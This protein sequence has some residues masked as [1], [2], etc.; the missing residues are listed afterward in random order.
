MR[1]LRILPALA[2][3]AM[4]L[5]PPL[6][7][8]A[9]PPR[10]SSLVC[11]DMEDDPPVAVG[12]PCGPDSRVKIVVQNDPSQVEPI[13]VMVCVQDVGCTPWPF[14]LEAEVIEETLQAIEGDV[15]TILAP[16]VGPP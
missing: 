1:A 7:A 6:A 12:Q 2:C 13:Q 14:P 10:I 11:V 3:L 4:A 16:L 8:A 15:G 9:Q 5:A